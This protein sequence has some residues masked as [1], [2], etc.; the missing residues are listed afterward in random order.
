[1]LNTSIK[2]IAP[3]WYLGCDQNCKE[4]YFSVRDKKITT[5][6][7]ERIRAIDA[8]MPY[9]PVE[10]FIVGGNP[11][12]DPHLEETVNV[13]KQRGVM[14]EVLSNSWSMPFVKNK[15]ALLE[16]IDHRAATFFGADAA[17]H[18]GLNGCRGSFERLRANLRGDYSFIP[19]IN[20][21]PANKDSVYEIIKG[22]RNFIKFDTVWT[23]RIMPYGAA[24]GHKGMYLGAEDLNPIF[25]QLSRARDDFKLKEVQ[26][27]MTAPTCL[28]NFEYHGMNDPVCY[29]VSMW[30]LDPKGRLFVNSFELSKPELAL[31]NGRPVWEIKGNLLDAI[32]DNS[33]V[34]SLYG[35]NYMP[36][37][38]KRCE[39]YKNCFGG[40]P[41]WNSAGGWN[42]DPMMSSRRQR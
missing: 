14:V 32:N 6:M 23:Q 1:M 35:K 7:D 37:S 27:N 20:I 8:I 15:S 31:F 21:M 34:R 40:Y 26:W 39:C 38:C 4:C 22:L 30:G 42:I 13:L 16:K 25:K 5:P 19:V 11:T 17:M 33:R 28:V 24:I 41:I 2:Y 18:D 10:F 36:A 12:L 29:G 9:N 3:H